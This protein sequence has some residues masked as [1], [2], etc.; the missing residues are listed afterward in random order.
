M[1]IKRVIDDSSSVLPC[2][3]QGFLQDMAT[4]QL[5]YAHAVIAVS[6]FLTVVYAT[7]HFFR[8]TACLIGCLGSGWLIAI[9]VAI[10]YL[11]V[12]GFA[13]SSSTRASFLSSYTLVATLIVPVMIV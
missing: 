2:R 11:L 1:A 8:S 13:C 12:D 6:R 7:K 3:L 4:C 5:M 10:P 9:L